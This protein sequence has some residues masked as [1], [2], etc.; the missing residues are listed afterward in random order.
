MWPQI[1]WTPSFSIG[2]SSVGCSSPLCSSW[3]AGEEFLKIQVFKE[4]LRNSKGKGEMEFIRNRVFKEF[5]R[6]SIIFSHKSSMPVVSC[7]ISWTY[8]ALPCSV[9]VCF[10]QRVTVC[11]ITPSSNKNLLLGLCFCYSS[12]WIYL[13]DYWLPDAVGLLLRIQIFFNLQ[14]V[15]TGSCNLLLHPFPVPLLASCL[16]LLDWY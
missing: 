5:L 6:N 3:G 4:F 13:G 10:I 8:N 14:P 7:L 9:L 1:L 11:W 2:S 12:P 15:Q 16:P